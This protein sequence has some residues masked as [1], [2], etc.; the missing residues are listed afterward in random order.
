VK[1]KATARKNESSKIPTIAAKLRT[2]AYAMCVLL[3]VVSRG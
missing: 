3:T 2:T 1:E